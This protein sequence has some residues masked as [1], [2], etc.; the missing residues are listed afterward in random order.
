MQ[1]E[2]QYQRQQLGVVFT[3]RD[4][5]GRP[6]VREIMTRGALIQH[7]GHEYVTL[8]DYADELA[9]PTYILIEQKLRR[10]A[11]QGIH[12]EAI[13]DESK[14]RF[15]LEAY[16][17]GNISPALEK[18]IQGHMKVVDDQR[19]REQNPSDYAKRCLKFYR[20]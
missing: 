2:K 1:K 10:G 6:E 11:I 19:R 20:K 17:H 9:N 18:A 12:C 3:S 13:A 15:L 8:S 5:K 16:H 14:L 7:E 4:S